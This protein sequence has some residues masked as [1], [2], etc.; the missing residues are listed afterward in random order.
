MRAPGAG[1]DRGNLYANTAMAYGSDTL[2]ANFVRGILTG[3]INMCLLYSEPGAGSDLAGIRTRADLKGDDYIV[4]GQKVWTSGAMTADYGMLIAR[5][6]PEPARTGFAGP[7]ASPSSGSEV[8]S[9]L[10]KR[11]RK[12]AFSIG[13]MCERPVR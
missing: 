2:K 3:E 6:L 8:I 13:S 1:Q 12:S 10:R 11:P 9:S 4:N 5:T 7:P